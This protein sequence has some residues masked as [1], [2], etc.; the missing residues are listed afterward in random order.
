MAARALW[1][2]VIRIGNVEVPVKLY[3][4]IQDRSVH[5]RLLHAKDHAP[6]KQAM[7]NPNTDEVV[8]KES[9]RR[10]YF[11]PEGE[12]V[13][14]KDE[15]LKLLEPEPSREIRLLRFLPPELIDHRWYRRPYYLGPDGSEKSYAALVGALADSGREGLAKWA[16]RNKSYVG[17]LRLNRGYPLLMALRHAEEVVSLD[18]IKAPSGRDLDQRELSMARQLIDMLAADFE[19]E[20]YH[21]EYRERVMKL[22][23]TK[24]SGGRV[25]AI[26]PRCKARSDD[27]SKALEASL[28]QGKEQ[29]KEQR[30]DKELKRA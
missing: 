6:V 9:I 12:L 16:M 24:A 14:L 28:R 25:T 30:K 23:Q 19:P 11:T 3:S 21:D 22:I 10:G 15:E 27:L 2:A 7:V 5:F 29:R 8:T 18:T 17:T 13:M 1:K 4:A 26:E 20:Q